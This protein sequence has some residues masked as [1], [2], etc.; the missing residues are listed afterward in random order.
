LSFVTQHYNIARGAIQEPGDY[1][2][3]PNSVALLDRRGRVVSNLPGWHGEPAM[4]AALNTLAAQ[5]R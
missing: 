1:P 2:P 4:T 3:R 5:P